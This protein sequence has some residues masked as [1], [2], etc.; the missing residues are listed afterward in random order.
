MITGFDLYS[1]DA[2]WR[3]YH[4]L[5]LTDKTGHVGWAEMDAA[6]SPPGV[7]A[8]IAKYESFVL[9]R[10]ALDHERIF[11]ELYYM[12]RP[13][14]WG[15]T[16]EALGAIEN[17]LLD[18]KGKILG[19]PCHQLF[20]GKQRDEVPIYWSHCAT[21]RISQSRHYDK[22]I[23]SLD[24]VRQVGEEA[25]DQGFKAIKTNLFRYDDGKPQQWMPGFGIQWDPGL[26]VSPGLLRD[27]RD[28]L[29]ALR[30]GAGPDVEIL[31]DLNFNVRTEGALQI[32]RALNDFPLYW[33]E[34]DNHNPEALAYIRSHSPHPIASLETL[35]G[36]RQ[37]LPYL[38]SQAVD[39][40]IVDAIWNGAWQGMKIANAAEA[41]DVNVAGHNFY[42]HLAT[43]TNVHL[44]AALPNVRVLE[45]DVDRLSWDHE[46]FTTV[47][48]IRDGSIVVPDT[49]GWGTE[50]NEEALT[51]HPPQE[52][53][54][55]LGL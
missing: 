45:C 15:I 37:F 4:L 21:W 29:E 20:G 55:F 35:F 32:L 17:A 46:I 48:E 43:M 34:L 25:R 41:L 33:V 11:S 27:I 52:A 39:C 13:A 36:L 40:A 16:M 44:L 2:G 6:Y 23:T 5:K 24:G 28:H 7:P 42:G 22:A 51:R 53:M 8:A 38:Q 18:L 12:S 9:G 30:D 31:L 54:S 19:V 3:N 50:I 49:P 47:P 10:S 26:P 1:C 14:P